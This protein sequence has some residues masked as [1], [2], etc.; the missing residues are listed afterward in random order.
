VVDKTVIQDSL[1]NAFFMWSHYLYGVFAL[2]LLVTLLRSRWF[3]GLF[4]EWLV[5]FIA[6]TGTPITLFYQGIRELD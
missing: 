2:L 5:N 3:K 4:G 1:I 6:V